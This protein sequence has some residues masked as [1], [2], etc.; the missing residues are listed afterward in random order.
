MSQSTSERQRSGDTPTG[1]LLLVILI[2]MVIAGLFGGALG[3]MS[4]GS[5]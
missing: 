1:R 2:L 4:A 5:L 3:A